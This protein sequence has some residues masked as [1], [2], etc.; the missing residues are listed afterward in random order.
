MELPRWVETILRARRYGAAVLAALLALLVWDMPLDLGDF[1]GYGQRLLDGRLDGVYDSGW[2]QAGP[3]QLL[4]SRALMIGGTHGMPARAVVIAVN[5]GLVL[6]AMTLCGR[7]TPDRGRRRAVR[8][9]ATGLLVL[10][11]MLVPVPWYG[12][13]AELAVPGLWAYASLCQKRQR[14]VTA[15]ALLGLAVA[16]AP[17]AVLGFPCLLAVSG[18]V[19]ALRTWV[20]GGLAGIATY[21][22]FVLAGHFAMFRHVWHVDNDTLVKIL[23]PGMPDVTWEMRLI[24]AVLVAGGC[25]AVA[26]WCRGQRLAYAVAPATALLVRVF[27]DPVTLRYY[28]GPIA[29]ATVLAFILVEQPRRQALALLL[30]YAAAFAAL[31]TRQVTGSAACLVLLV[32]LVSVRPVA[33]ARPAD[34][35]LT[36][37]V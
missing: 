36:P 27:S 7:L 29:V 37:A 23:L 18:P 9:T 14:T 21:L 35:L 13:P 34:T 1:A 22:P 20:L 12:H 26:W 15:A 28:W 8:E 10:L 2:N 31:A 33:R 24:Q 16:I 4:I 11:W 32:A 30:G 3:L 19:R 17:W 6:A 5:V 25:A